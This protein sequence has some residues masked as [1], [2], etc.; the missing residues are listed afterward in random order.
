MRATRC[1]LVSDSTQPSTESVLLSVTGEI[2]V[3]SE[4]YSFLSR[5]RHFFRSKDKQ[6]KYE[7]CDVFGTF[8]DSVHSINILLYC[9]ICMYSGVCF[10]LFET[11][12]NAIF[13]HDA[14]IFPGHA[15]FI[16]TLHPRLREL[17]AFTS[18][19]T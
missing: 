5:S 18:L 15:P 4:A 11:R 17:L 16:Y 10:L 9:V 1:Y 13:S 14:E 12:M 8:F 7:L 6:L 3:K 19:P 2:Q